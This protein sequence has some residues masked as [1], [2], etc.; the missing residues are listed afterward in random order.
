MQNSTQQPQ[1]ARFSGLRCTVVT[2]QRARKNSRM[3]FFCVPNAV[4]S[5]ESALR[6]HL[7]RQIFEQ[8]IEFAP[9]LQLAFDL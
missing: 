5:F 3:I 2:S 7:R 6:P 8:L 1:E 4:I 9:V